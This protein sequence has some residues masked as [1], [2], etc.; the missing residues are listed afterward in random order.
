MR[1]ELIFVGNPGPLTG[2]GN[3]TYL[4]PGLEPTLI[5]AGTGQD[6]HLL[7][8]AA[9]LDESNARLSQKKDLLAKVLVTHCHSD[10]VSGVPAIAERW[11]LAVFAKMP[12]K[13]RDEQYR[14]S[15]KALEDGDLIPAGDSTLQVVH[16]PGHSPD[17][18]CF[19]DRESGTLFSGDLVIAGS[20]VVIPASAGGV[21]VA[22][23]NSLRLVL[24]MKP[25]CLLPAHGCSIDEPNTVIQAYLDHRQQ[26]EDQVIAALQQGAKTIDD[27]VSNVYEP[28]D[29]GLIRAAQENVLAHL[30]KL[31]SEGRAAHDGT[32]WWM[33]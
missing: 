9:K 2:A 21:L 32:V 33:S 16:T 30:T 28:L 6:T 1:H 20:S 12:W 22:Y 24:S 7:A 14:V 5:D 31:V 27:I 25:A 18:L 15:W 4:L 23:L 29:S 10:H 11:P 17:H 8:L 26:R 13:D 19:F 3:N